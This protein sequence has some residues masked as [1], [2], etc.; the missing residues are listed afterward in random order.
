VVIREICGSKSL[1][2]DDFSLV[3][4]VRPRLSK[5]GGGISGFKAVADFCVH[6]RPVVVVVGKGGV[7]LGQSEMWVLPMNFLGTPSVSEVVAYDFDHFNIRVV[8]PDSAVSV[9]HYMGDFNGSVHGEGF[10]NF[11]PGCK[12]RVETQEK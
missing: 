4:G 6:R 7:D 11:G 10:A 8:D 2:H 3:N 9:N 1:L 12:S 5:P